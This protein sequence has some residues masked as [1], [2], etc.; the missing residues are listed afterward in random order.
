M[1]DAADHDEIAYKVYLPGN[2]VGLLR[3]MSLLRLIPI[4]PYIVFKSKNSRQ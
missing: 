3:P 2:P 1:L 4:N